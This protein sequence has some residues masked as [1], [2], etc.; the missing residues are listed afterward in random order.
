MKKQNLI[1]FTAIASLLIIW[2][3]CNKQVQKPAV[4]IANEPLTTV[5]LLATNTADPTDTPSAKWIQLDPTGAIPPDTSHAT[6]TLR[7]NAAYNVQ[8]KVL[9]SLND[10]TPTII[11]RE[12]YHLFCFDIAAG[13][14]LTVTRTDHDNNNP[15]L[16]I[17][18]ADQFVTS[19]VSTGSFDVT[20]R[21]QPNVKDGT[22]APGS[23]DIEG[24][25]T[26]KIK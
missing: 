8:I 10:V 15:S 3:S 13:L 7:H 23:T 25:F 4:N 1:L 2:S 12:N 14:N 11:E 6:L 18:L 22:C 16:P 9:D 19:A 17:G 21:H 26:V 5:E 24:Y 20:L